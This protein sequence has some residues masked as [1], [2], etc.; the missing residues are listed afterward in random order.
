[1]PMSMSASDWTR[2]Q[3]RKAGINYI[4]DAT[5]ELNPP[6]PQ[7]LPYGKAL[8]ISSSVGGS[9]IRRTAGDYT[10]FVASNLADYVLKSSGTGRAGE[11]VENTGTARLTVRMIGR[12]PGCKCTTTL[13]IKLPKT[14][15]C[16]KCGVAQHV[17]IN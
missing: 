11:S 5:R 6:M 3:S 7:Q 1:M 16:S 10:N 13:G 15:I 12:G 4:A 8:L 14:G 9:K 17:R 2:L